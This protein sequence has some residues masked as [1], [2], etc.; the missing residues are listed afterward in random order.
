MAFFKPS[1]I[2]YLSAKQIVADAVNATADAETQTRAGRHIAAAVQRWNTEFCWHFALL[3]Y[4][5]IE[6]VPPFTVAN[7]TVT[8]NSTTITSTNDF[9]TAGVVAQDLIVGTGLYGEARATSV[10]TTTITSSVV[11]NATP[12]AQTLQFQRRDY[13]LPADFGYLYSARLTQNP[14]GLMPLDMRAWDRG[15]SDHTNTDIPTHYTLFS[16][17]GVGKIRMI[18]TPAQADHLIL[19]YYRRM[20]IPST[21]GTAIDVP[22]EWEYGIL[23]M[24]KADL[25]MDRGMADKAS[26]W[27]ARSEQAILRAKSQTVRAPDAD[28]GFMPSAASINT[29]WNPN[30]IDAYID[31]P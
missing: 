8:D 26:H 27:A 15:R 24:A 5:G 3:T 22:E 30:S 25:A 13:D 1:A 17:G 12:G 16:A 18:P 20:T 23:A 11:A 28:T 6:L 10:V 19:Q 21:D 2:T 7:C 29:G 4:T 31:W 9:A 14:R